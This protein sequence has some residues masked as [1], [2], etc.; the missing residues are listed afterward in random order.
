MNNRKLEDY[1]D[2]LQAEFPS[3]KREQIRKICTRGC[4]GIAQALKANECVQLHAPRLGKNR[5]TFYR[6]D[7]VPQFPKPNTDSPAG[8]DQGA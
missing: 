7:N 1:L 4:G 3:L 6:H 8:P 5:M 2:Q